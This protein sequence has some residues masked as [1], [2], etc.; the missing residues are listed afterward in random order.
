[1]RDDDRTG[2]FNAGIKNY[3]QIDRKQKTKD[4][5]GFKIFLRFHPAKQPSCRYCEKRNGEEFEA[6]HQD[7]FHREPPLNQEG[8]EPAEYEHIA[9]VPGFIFHSK[10]NRRN[11]GDEREEPEFYEDVLKEFQEVVARKPEEAPW[12]GRCIICDQH[13]RDIFQRRD[14]KPDIVMKES[15]GERKYQNSKDS[16]R[17]ASE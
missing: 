8:Q 17:I 15:C 2:F 5:N 3:C 12:A 14:D 10:H 1:M 4:H 6:E 7:F 11:S 9:V 13:C 16:Q